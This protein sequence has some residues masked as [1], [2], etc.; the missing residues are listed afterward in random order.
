[1]VGAR[2]GVGEV[3]GI[4]NW[5]VVTGS[6]VREQNDRDERDSINGGHLAVVQKDLSAYFGNGEQP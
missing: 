2:P 3:G 5:N 4:S 1:M 6:P